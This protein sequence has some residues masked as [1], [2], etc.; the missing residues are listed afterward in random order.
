MC[1]INGIALA[2][3]FLYIAIRPVISLVMSF[4]IDIWI[5]KYHI[6][7]C[8]LSPVMF[9]CNPFPFTVHNAM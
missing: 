4:T 1:K 6:A 8:M 5:M 2:S 9:M 7:K 3:L